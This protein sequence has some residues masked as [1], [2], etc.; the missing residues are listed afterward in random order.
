[1]KK[2][3]YSTNKGYSLIEM[4]VYIAILSFVS[5]FVITALVLTIKSFIA[6]SISRNIVDNASLAIDRIVR[7]VR[8]SN[9]VILGSSVFDVNP[10]ALHIKTDDGTGTTTTMKFYVSNGRL[11][12]NRGTTTGIYLTSDKLNVTNL[13]FRHSNTSTS[14]QSIKIEMTLEGGI[15]ETYK[16][17]NFYNTAVLRKLY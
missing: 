8:L 4:I 9:E 5:V 7:E 11:V 1:M 13:V 10:G 2:T 16:S 6:F 17:E 14:S 12:F 15:G 3:I